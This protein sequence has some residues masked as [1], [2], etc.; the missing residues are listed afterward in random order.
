MNKD[1]ILKRLKLPQL[2]NECLPVI[3]IAAS[4]SN[5]YFNRSGESVSLKCQE[6]DFNSTEG[7]GIKAS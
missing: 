5:Q 4:Y 7:G 2:G 6:E 1:Q 3:N